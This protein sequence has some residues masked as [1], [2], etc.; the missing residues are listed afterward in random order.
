MNKGNLTWHSQKLIEF[1]DQVNSTTLQV[2]TDSGI[3]D[4][5]G[6]SSYHPLKLSLKI[7]DSK[8]KKNISV[9][10]PYQYLF[11][12]KEMF[13]NILKITSSN[14]LKK[15]IC[16]KNVDKIIE[17]QR[18]STDTISIVLTDK[19][20]DIQYIGF[21]IKNSEFKFLLNILD[22]VLKNYTT[23]SYNST[24]TLNQIKIIKNLESLN[25]LT[26]RSYDRIKSIDKTSKQN[27]IKQHSN[28]SKEFLEDEEY[29][30]HENVT[31]TSSYTSSPKFEI[32]MDEIENM[33]IGDEKVLNIVTEPK[34]RIHEKT[35]YTK[36]VGKSNFIEGFLDDDIKNLY[37]WIDCFTLVDENSTE[38]MLLPFNMIISKAVPDFYKEI[39]NKDFIYDYNYHLINILKMSNLDFI[40]NGD[41]KNYPM[42]T[43]DN[44]EISNS[45]N[46]DMW[47]FML[48][49]VS[50]SLVHR[51]F[52]N[53]VNKFSS[54]DKSKYNNILIAEKFLRQLFSVLLTNISNMDK[55]Q[56]D[57]VDHFNFLVH[58]K[59]FEYIE[60]LYT[61]ISNG[62]E[63]KFNIDGV[64]ILVKKYINN[65][66]SNT[67]E[68]RKFDNI[69]LNSIESLK[70]KLFPKEILEEKV[71]ENN[72]KSYNDS[73][74][75]T[76]DMVDET[77][78]YNYEK[79]Y[80]PTPLEMANFKLFLEY[81]TIREQDLKLYNKYKD[82]IK[83]CGQ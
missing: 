54:I 2:S 74:D 40:N 69:E 64:R 62:G 8:T 56:N 71:E 29:P 57:L 82:V 68:F 15:T 46:Y 55:F 53:Q 76:N 66:I 79:D 9:S 70:D 65:F 38:M 18:Q 50:V 73:I 19:N 6:V 4:N 31:D 10:L 24:Q 83:P 43:T 5:S 22:D 23:L 35:N 39:K 78:L 27:F 3:S 17:V 11:S 21:G 30:T 61:S 75:T 34:K 32:D 81:G 48:D 41:Y 63:I 37:R 49:I 1:Y 33:N 47:N 77:K 52:M 13:E 67:K 51:L 26:H 28:I 58:Q 60:N 59:K 45:N 80:V 72:E 44:I 12:V 25:D 16:N 42:Y 7:K 36:V 14:I 20:T